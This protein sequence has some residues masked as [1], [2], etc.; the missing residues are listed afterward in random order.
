M[1]L[2]MYTPEEERF[3]LARLEE[4][5]R[6]AERALRQHE[7]ALRVKETGTMVGKAIL[8]CTL[9][10]G[11]LTVAAAAPNAFGVLGNT[12]LR[13]RYFGKKAFQEQLS[14]LKRGKYVRAEKTRHGYEVVLTGRGRKLAYADIGRSLTVRKLPQWDGTWWLVLFDIPRRHNAARNGLRSR[15]RHM[16]LESLQDSVFASKYPCADEVWFT[17]RLFN[18]ERYVAIAHVDSLEGFGE[19][20]QSITKRETRMRT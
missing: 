17:A 20:L 16:G 18:V 8:A 9:A 5:L 11:V 4:E 1:R 15:L 10:A 14:S 7:V 13:K 3:L 2:K 19:R 12:L 6:I